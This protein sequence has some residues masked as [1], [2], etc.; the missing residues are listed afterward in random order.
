MHA[1]RGG[2]GKT[3]LCEL[4]TSL[5]GLKQ[6]PRTWY[7]KLCS[8]LI[9][10]YGFQRS[11][12]DPCMFRL[13][14]KEQYVYMLVY[15]DDF[16]IG[17]VSSEGMN[18]VKS[19]LEADYK[20]TDL[21]VPTD[22]LGIELKYANAKDSKTGRAYCWLH[23]T[24]YANEIL[25]RFGMEDCRGISSPWA[26]GTVLDPDDYLDKAD[27]AFPFAEFCG[28][29]I[30]FKTRPDITYA[31][32][33]LCK[34]MKKAT[35]PAV[36]AAKR[37]LRYL[38][39]HA[40]YGICFGQNNIT[41]A[42]DTMTIKQHPE[43]QRF[44]AHFNANELWATSDSAFA[45]QT[46][47]GKTTYGYNIFFNGGLLVQKS[48]EFGSILRSTVAA[49]YIALSETGSM[50]KAIQLLFEFFD[51]TING[52]ARWSDTTGLRAGVTLY[53]DNQGSIYLVKKRT[54]TD[55]SRMI[56]VRFHD[57]REWY[58]RSEIDVQYVKTEWQLS[59]GMTK[60]LPPTKHH[61]ISQFLVWP[62]SE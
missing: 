43:L 6:A 15:V 10:D 37:L 41:R 24:R 56:A 50:I 52:I 28:S 46:Y 14:Y 61:Q 57:I 23:Q 51:H 44:S 19:R 25:K 54:L 1:P 21:G 48:R 27:E 16:L 32:S 9:D 31:V 42:V 34:F 7:D 38:K 12:V 33:K 13:W 62:V 35:S 2:F 4:L 40:N 45:D 20:M 58:E 47:S 49:E 59:D 29:M 22:F 53:G 18:Y 11:P 60:G 17:S 39:N 55:K 30:Y 5:Y 36:Q 3:K 8:S 26:A